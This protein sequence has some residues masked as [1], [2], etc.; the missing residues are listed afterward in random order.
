[1]SFFVA[2]DT[3]ENLDSNYFLNGVMQAKF[4]TL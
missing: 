1:M 2:P 3:R 4:G